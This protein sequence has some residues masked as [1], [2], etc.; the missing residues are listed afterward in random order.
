MEE[1]L[2]AE[3]D[4]VAQ[5][6]A[7]G[8]AEHRAGR[9]A[10]AETA[11]RQALAIQPGHCDALHFLGLIAHQMGDNEKAA[12]HIR[13]A[14]AANGVNPGYHC[15]LGLILCQLDRPT[16][17]EVSLRT[18]L[19]L[20][21]EYPEALNCLG[22]TLHELGRPGEAE[23]CYQ[24]ALRL[25]P[26]FAE[27]F[28]NLGNA[29][30]ALGRPDEAETSCRRAVSFEPTLAE[31]H[32]NLG[33]ALA[34]QGRAAEAERSYREAL[35]LRP[36]RPAVSNNLGAT[37]SLLGRPA[38]AAICF[39]DAVR[40]QPDFADAQSNL[41]F[42]LCD[43]RRPAEAQAAAREAIRLQPEFA[44]AH[45]NLSY[46]L[47]LEGRMEE[48]WAEYEWRWKTKNM[49]A[50]ARAFRAPL[51]TGQPI[52]ER[53][54]LLHAEQGMGD[55]LQ[56]CR[57]APMIEPR[58]RV[59]LEVQAPLARLV[60]RLPGIA[61]VVLRGEPLPP[62]DL[63]CPLL[64]L[65]RAFRTTVCTVPATA[66]YL[67]AYPEA[68]AVWK[69]RLAKLPFGLKVG[70]VW[71]GEPRAG[72]PD[73]T[74]IDARRS[75]ALEALAPLAE[76]AGVIFISLQKG[77]PAVQAASPPSGMILVD[78][79]AELG[80]FAD[81]A[82]LVE[83]LDLVI[84][85]D[86]SVAHLAGAMGKPVWLL[87][88]FDSCWRW[89]LDRDDSPWYPTLRQFRQ[90]APGDWTSPIV[91]VQSALAR[92]AAANRDHVSTASAIPSSAAERGS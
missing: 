10:Q 46:A 20:R 18:A 6:V 38:E 92:L 70:L 81:T 65:P 28:N 32:A 44:D 54:I 51:W 31:A 5:W 91:A 67:S 78:F 1:R 68:A 35:R 4:S 63:H 37:L 2:N 84:S 30:F 13:A 55:T 3:V 49:A 33:I 41:A 36:E 21:P 80:D 64:S 19:R 43:L 11:Y 25:K 17:A 90:G 29:L 85:V 72:S 75:I 42:A 12:R 58:A 79:T 89:L 26:D 74:A 83:N 23:A 53:T 8:F 22:M 47:L 7:R 59:V 61:Q 76:V 69:D 66:P 86:T 87:N 27:A 45:N 24:E 52:G 39:R 73:L 82:A 88:R 77:G 56:F 48:G 40:L 9:L 16:D 15:N 57:Y 14:I 62:F 34:A 60:L 50:G 71:A